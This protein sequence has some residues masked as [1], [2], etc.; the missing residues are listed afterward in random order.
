MFLRGQWKYS[1]WQ[2]IGIVNQG[3]EKFKYF[4]FTYLP[5]GPKQSDIKSG[6]EKIII[7]WLT[8]NNDVAWPWCKR[9]KKQTSHNWKPF[10]RQWWFCGGLG[11]WGLSATMCICM[12]ERGCFSMSRKDAPE[13]LF[14]GCYVIESRRRTVP[15]SRLLGILPSPA[16]FV[17]RNFE[18]VCPPRS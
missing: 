2:K 12:R 9:R 7:T 18:A 15:M 14:Q 6:W 4:F 16:S 1:D 10:F 3:V 8:G 11:G 17:A 5:L 13:P